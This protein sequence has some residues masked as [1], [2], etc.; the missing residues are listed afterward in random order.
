M[1]YLYPLVLLRG[2]NLTLRPPAP[3]DAPA[4]FALGRDPEVVRWFSW[5][6]YRSEDEPRAWIAEQ[7]RLREAG[8]RLE[9]L[10]VDRERGLLGVTGLSEPSARDRRAVVGAW[11]TPSAWGTG[12]NAEAK[13]LVLHLAFAGL[14]L[15]RV[16]AYA[17]PANGRSQRALEKVGFTR[18]GLL[19]QFH[20]HGDVAKDVLVYAI[21]RDEWVGA[22]FPVAVEGQLPGALT[23]R[24]QTSQWP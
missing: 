8:E 3:E 24:S 19:R 1:R 11:L 23:G 17:D 6:P 7:A 21:L 18:E 13:A 20:R 10:V 12:V 15:D 4:L 14:G 5:G 2:P 16:G 22:P 9:L